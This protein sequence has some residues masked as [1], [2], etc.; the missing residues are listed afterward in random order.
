MKDEAEVSV[1]NG[2]THTLKCYPKDVIIQIAELAKDE[3]NNY[4]TMS[5]IALRWNKE[6][7]M[8]GHATEKDF[9]KSA[10]RAFAF[11][12]MRGKNPED[13]VM[14]YYNK[15]TKWIDNIIFYDGPSTDEDEGDG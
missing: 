5:L 15:N 12:K 8:K 2:I 11:L 13:Y 4:E 1:V 10:S 6:I 3:L 14:V 7:P 9:E